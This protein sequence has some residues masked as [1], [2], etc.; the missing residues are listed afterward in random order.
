[1][2]IYIYLETSFFYI[3]PYIIVLSIPLLLFV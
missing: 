2:V 1:M 3:L